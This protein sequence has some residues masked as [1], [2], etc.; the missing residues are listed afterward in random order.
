[1]Q[2]LDCDIVS[3]EI[4]FSSTTEISNLS[5]LQRIT[6]NGECLEEWTFDFGFV[7]PGSTNTWQQT[8][9]SAGRDL[10][11]DPSILSG[12]LLIHTHFFNGDILMNTNE[13]RIVYVLN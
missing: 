10:M 1:M 2:I 13:F 5:L 12:N 11:I 3:R 9:Q 7:M 8:I 6:Y 4:N